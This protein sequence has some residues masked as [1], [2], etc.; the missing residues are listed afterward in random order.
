MKNNILTVIFLLVSISFFANAQTKETRNL[1]SFD[2]V[3]I[4][5]AFKVYMSQGSKEEI[6]IETKSADPK[7]I[8]TE[9]IGNTLKIYPK[10]KRWNYGKS[11]VSLYLNF[12]KMEKLAISG[13]ID[14]IGKTK[15]TSNSLVISSSG[16]GNIKMD[17]KT[18][19]LEAH[20]S[21][22][23]D[24]ELSGS[25][26]RQEFNI[27]G[28]GD[29]DAFDLESVDSKIAIAGSGEAKISVSGSLSASI[30][31]S[32]DVK[33]KGNPDLKSVNVA[34]SGHLSKAN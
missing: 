17:V 18:M 26:K 10:D 13:A 8:I 30:A 9:V 14:I 24:M 11:E 3:E 23:S 29:I 32:G 20:L 5:G 4:S 7:L 28:S 6:T 1:E 16:S 27:S 2:E 19:E 21:G 31:G 33:Y 12:E 34:G 25:T 22:S 15:V